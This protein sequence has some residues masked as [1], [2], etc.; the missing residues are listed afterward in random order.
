MPRPAKHVV[1]SRSEIGS[2]IRALREQRRLTQAELATT[3][4]THQANVSQIERGIRGLTLQQ[5]V[6]LARALHIS[7]DKLLG[8]G[9]DDG[10]PVAP[11]NEKL[12]R[13]VRRVEQLPREQQEAVVKILDGFLGAQGR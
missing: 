13:R 8:V 7:P 3:L 12:M 11:R 9:K 2:R 6:K 4:G 10:K 5:T 1:M